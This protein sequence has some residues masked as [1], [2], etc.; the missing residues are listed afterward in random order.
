MSKIFIFHITQCLDIDFH[1]GENV[2]IDDILNAIGVAD[3]AKINFPLVQV[4]DNKTVCVLNTQSVIMLEKYEI[5]LRATKNYNIH[6]V[7]E[8]LICKMINKNEIII[9]GRIKSVS[10]ES[11]S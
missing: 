3:I 4:V 8:E 11:D 2:M 10:W 5:L 9:S 1:K 6:I 7:G